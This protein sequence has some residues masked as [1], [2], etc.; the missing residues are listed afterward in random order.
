ML[1]QKFQNI[2]MIDIKHLNKIVSKHKEAR[3]TTTGSYVRKE[4]QAKEMRV[5]IQMT[6]YVMCE[7]AKCRS[8]SPQHVSRYMSILTSPQET[9]VWLV[10]NL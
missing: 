10:Y 6:G 9:H 5:I 1:S 4:M 3:K 8:N 2:Y 7:V